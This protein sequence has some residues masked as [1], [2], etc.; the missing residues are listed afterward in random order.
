M[1]QMKDFFDAERKRVMEPDAFFTQRVM[2]HLDE[3]LNERQAQDFG[4]WDIVPSSTRPVLAVA[5]MLIVCFVGLE[6]FVPQVPERGM[7]ES[8]LATEQ[9]PAES[10]LYN[11][12]DVPSRQDV[13]EQLI[14]PEEQQ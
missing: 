13:L 3:R 14:A 4:I 6:M 12:T 1:N 8:F 11:D 10:F 2:A 9:S 7:V 5:L